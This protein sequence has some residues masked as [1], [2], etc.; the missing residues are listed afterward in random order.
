MIGAL[1][2]VEFCPIRPEQLFG[3]PTVTFVFTL[4]AERS[5]YRL[6]DVVTG[7]ILLRVTQ[8]VASATRIQHLR[9]GSA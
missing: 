5:V 1:I 9:T 4:V 6:Q 7:T 3:L 2:K 8:W